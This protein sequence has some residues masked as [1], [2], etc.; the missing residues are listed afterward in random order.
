MGGNDF[1]DLLLDAH[2]VPND[3][4]VKKPRHYTHPFNEF[5]MLVLETAAKR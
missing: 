5:E 1:F 4:S 2:G 3:L